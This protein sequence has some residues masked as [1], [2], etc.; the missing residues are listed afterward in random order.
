[1]FG[2]L[3]IHKPSGSTS[4]DVVNRVQRLVRGV[5]VGHAGTLDPLA[6]GVLVVALGPAT[7]LVEYV[8]RMPKTYVG[9][10]LL[11]R[12]SDTEDIE[13]NVVELPDPPQP[14]R[15][16]IEAALP[17]FV[18]TI[19]QLPP[20]FSALKVHGQRAYALARRG[21]QV[22][23]QARPIAIHRLSV[24]RYE[25]PELELD[26]CCGSGTY[27]RSLGR[28]L[29]RSLGTAA[30][31]S[32]LVRTA[33]GEFRLADALEL[34]SLTPA[35][36]ES[37]L[38]PP[39]LAVAQL[40]A[41]RLSDDEVRRLANGLAISNRWGMEDAEIAAL[42]GQGRLVAILVPRTHGELGPVRNFPCGLPTK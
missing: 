15:L 39:R 4:R 19:Q 1:M 28:D 14:T 35:A 27:I 6:T 12:S 20:A 13:G 30:V 37:N 2:L 24:V 29:A 32:A 36:C 23:L 31:M 9:T 18:G 40:P 25:Y 3:N 38:L 21:E 33:I 11:G 5:K 17:A 41:A 7:R 8:Q 42:D 22:E 26:V 16:E 34:D 10:F